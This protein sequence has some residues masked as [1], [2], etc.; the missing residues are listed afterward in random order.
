MEHL[1]FSRAAVR[2]ILNLGIYVNSIKVEVWA[3]VVWVQVQHRRPFFM[4]KKAFTNHFREW[5]KASGQGLS[6]QWLP[7]PRAYGVRGSTGSR[8]LVRLEGDQIS[9]TCADYRQQHEAW[10]R[11]CCKH[12]YAVLAQLGYGSLTEYQ[13][14]RQRQ[15]TTA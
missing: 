15:L 10:G 5:R 2:R 1:I 14:A 9:C 12:G 3:S 11:G 6:V 8:Y 13:A 4:S 7:V